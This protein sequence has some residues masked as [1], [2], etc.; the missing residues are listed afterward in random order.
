MVTTDIPF[1][2]SQLI[3]DKIKFPQPKKCKIS[4]LVGVS[5]STHSLRVIILNNSALR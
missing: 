5:S 4:G 1:Q 3:A 2:N